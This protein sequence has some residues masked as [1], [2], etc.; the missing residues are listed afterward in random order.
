MKIGIYT[1]MP[2]TTDFTG[3]YGVTMF[4]FPLI[5]KLKQ[6]GHE[7][8]YFGRIAEDKRQNIFCDVL[9][10]K[11]YIMDILDD[12]AVDS[13]IGNISK[14]DIALVY[15][16]PPAAKEE[17]DE[18]NNFMRM[19]VNNRVKVL[20]WCGDLWHPPEDVSKCIT[21]LRPF[22]SDKFDG[23]YET[24]YRYD[25]FTHDLYNYEFEKRPRVIDYTYLGNFYNRF[26]N[27]K[28]KF[29]NLTGK[30]V[31]G[32]SWLRDP[33]RWNK[34][35]TV[36]NVLYVGE[37]PHSFALPL[38]AITKETFYINPDNYLEVGM[39][40]SRVYEAAM[41]GCKIDMDV[42]DL[43]TLEKAHKKFYEIINE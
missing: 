2:L 10:L 35:L 34:S 23:L 30:I 6:D 28:S 18:Q 24:A 22:A 19:A 36:K 5:K 31:V 20:F 33:D 37:V 12:V 40:T 25:Y 43:N 9:E 27:F 29:G 15:N 11:P 39:I 41:A 38:L 17:F 21:L 1:K 16:R 4:M 32:G 8:I 13:N 3:V 14:C 26:E 7:I 42:S